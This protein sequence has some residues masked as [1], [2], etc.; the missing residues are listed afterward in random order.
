MIEYFINLVINQMFFWITWTLIPV[1]IE[2]IPAIVSFF[3][4]INKSLRKK[5]LDLPD[6]LP[7]I[8]IIVPVYNSENT[9]F[10]CIK[11]IN[12]SS[13]P[14]ELIQVIFAD[15]NPKPD[16]S[17]QVFDEAHNKYFKTLN[18][19]WMKTEAGKAKAL[20]AALYETIGTYIINID[21][22]GILEKNALMNLILA[23]ENDSDIAAMTGTILTQ[24]EMIKENRN[25]MSTLLQLNEYFEYA[26]A[27]LSG[28]MME[29][30]KGQL[31]TMAGAFSA[32]RKEILYSTFMYNIDTVGEDTDMTFQIRDGKKRKVGLCEDA[33]FFVDPIDSLD[34]LYL[35]RQRWQRGEIEVTENYVG[36]NAKISNIF[37]NFMIRRMIVDHTFV[38]PKMIWIFASFIL[39]IFGYS[40]TVL[41][42]SYLIIYLLYVFVDLLNFICA[43]ILLKPFKDERIFYSKIWW[44]IFILPCYTFICSWIRLVGIINTMTQPAQWNS[45]RFSSE[46]K[47][48]KETILKDL[49]M[50]Y[51]GDKFE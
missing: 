35:Q 41:G 32:F 2:I 47:L 19:Y 25:K 1:V 43:R 30:G 49:R 48:I 33:I 7:F 3:T 42:L 45:R 16:K 4:L 15:N 20:N 36:E 22:D 11:S 44:I 10:E 38:F 26:Q 14:N 40:L 31:F 46:I 18:M 13:Y 12:D 21:S 34:T 37:N 8:S 39:V 50:V 23:F 5:R 9:L 27:F 29:A 6:K 51:K 17:F 28:R 24:K